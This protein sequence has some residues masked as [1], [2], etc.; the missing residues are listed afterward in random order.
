MDLI[1]PVDILS[2]LP[3]DFYDKLEEKKWQTRKEALEAL[4]VLL[5]NPKLLPGDYGELVKALK[6]VVSKDTNVVLVAMAGKCMASLARGLAKKFA[7]YAQVCV[8]AILEKFKEKK[9]AVV[10]ALRDAIDSIYPSTSLE[11]M[12][13]DLFEAMSS[14]NP[15]VKSETNLFLARALT[16]T[17]PAVLNKKFLKALTG[18]LIKNLNES[19]PSVRDASA[20]ALGTLHKLLGEKM[21]STYLVDVDALKM[22]KIKEFSENAV[23]V[24]KIPVIKKAKPAIGKPAAPTQVVAPSIRP[25]SANAVK[26][27][28]S[29]VAPGIRK[30]APKKPTAGNPAASSARGG[31]SGGNTT[32]ALPTERELTPE[33]VAEKASELLPGN[34]LADLGDANWKSRL[35][36]SETL[37]NAIADL[38][39]RPELS[40]LLCKVLCQ[41]PGLKDTNFQVVKLKLEAIQKVIETFKVSTITADFMINDVTE[42]LSDV[43]NCV[44]AGEILFVFRNKFKNIINLLFLLQQTFLRPWLKA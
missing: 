27:P 12:Q 11:N 35:S 19:D 13:E 25:P 44:P 2:Q 20:E 43:K 22:A 24:V 41:K 21:L 26:R 3:K 34:C 32:A 23:I 36:A 40:Q 37:L 14:K 5:K 39:P 28:G 17:L 4:E 9:A 38:T 18:A 6:K 42:K 31:S 16:K 1:D 15:S 10:A 30:L 29:S 33:E 7:P 8:S